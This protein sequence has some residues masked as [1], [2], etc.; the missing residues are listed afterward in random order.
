MT[1][2]LIETVGRFAKEREIQELLKSNP[3][4]FA[5]YFANPEDEF[6]IFSEY[7]V[8][9]GLV[10]F[11][12]FTSRSRMNVIFIEIKGADFHFL[13]LDETVSSEIKKAEEQIRDRFETV[14]KSYENFHRDAH[15][16]RRQVES[17]KTI[18]NSRM[19]NSTKL[20]CDPEKEIMLSGY[21]I[22]GTTTDDYAESSKKA[23][24]ERTNNPP[25]HFES[26][27]SFFRKIED[28][29]K[30]PQIYAEILKR[31]NSEQTPPIPIGQRIRSLV[32][33]AG[34]PKGTCGIVDEHWQSTDGVAIMVAWDLPGRK[35]PVNYSAFNPSE[36]LKILRDG[37][38]PCEFKDLELI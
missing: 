1:E 17:G 21:V 33:F 6:I 29:R 20:H 19:G 37:F 12:V 25:I 8:G 7:P 16:F 3:S 13:N 30:A 18:Y 4:E 27:N 26:W 31:T 34:V 36:Q 2:K 22:G 35:V 32:E 11:V 24:M 38:K 9:Y 23:A 28:K 15:A 14:L 5:K 10:D